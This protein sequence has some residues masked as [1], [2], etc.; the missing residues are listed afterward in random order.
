MKWRQ[1]QQEPE[2]SLPSSSSAGHSESSTT[3]SLVK[4]PCCEQVPWWTLLTSAAVVIA[5][6]VC[7]ASAAAAYDSSASI[8]SQA[9][10]AG[11]PFTSQE[12]NGATLGPAGAPPS[13]DEA[14]LD[15]LASLQRR[16]SARLSATFLFL[17]AAVASAL[18]VASAAASTASK[19]RTATAPPAP[20]SSPQGSPPQPGNSSGTTRD[21]GPRL[22]SRRSYGAWQWA[23][24]GCCL[25]QLLLCGWCAVLL[26]SG[27]LW[28]HALLELGG[29]SRRIGDAYT[30]AR[31]AISGGLVD[32][33]ISHD[34]VNP[35]MEQLLPELWQSRLVRPAVSSASDSL[36]SGLERVAE[37]FSVPVT[38]PSSSSPSS[39]HNDGVNSG[40]LA[41]TLSGQS[42]SCPSSVCIP[43]SDLVLLATAAPSAAA[44]SS[45]WSTS[46]TCDIA[47]LE[48]WR[49]LA[50]T[51]A[52]CLWLA[53]WS[54]LFTALGTALLA[55]Q[56]S[57]NAALFRIWRH[58]VH[59]GDFD[60]LAF[61][62]SG[63]GF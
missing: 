15:A 59:G 1:K 27:T 21:T 26:C 18:A 46:C 35:K 28:H 39:A 6:A 62:R 60:H 42:A 58:A 9:A 49:L 33:G 12:P 14:A 10:L 29:S 40:A 32:V 63:D 51:A 44:S 4:A 47:V 11:A 13:A 8:L 52:E 56:S 16:F 30:D 7:A 38:A 53:L 2:E 50:E 23:A 25:L 41:S 34:L 24:Y 48:R 45:P 57:A 22:M 20:G 3:T 17:A 43:G 36:K 61:S 19:Q 5:A 54:G 31:A 37:S 55:T